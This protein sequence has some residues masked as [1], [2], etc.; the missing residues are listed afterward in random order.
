MY[1]VAHPDLETTG[2]AFA[3]M[4]DGLVLQ[5]ESEP[6]KA[7]VCGNLNVRAAAHWVGV[8]IL[9]CFVRRF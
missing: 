8:A 5:L 9:G 4:D 7:G 3:L 2:L 1:A 6:I